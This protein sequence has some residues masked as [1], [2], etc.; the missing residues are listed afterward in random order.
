M[1]YKNRGRSESRRK[2]TKPER[3]TMNQSPLQWPVR[4]WTCAKNGT[5]V[6]LNER[7]LHPP[8][9]LI[10][11]VRPDHQSPPTPPSP[12]GPFGPPSPPSPPSPQRPFG[13]FGPK[14]S[15]FIADLD[16]ADGADG[17][18]GYDAA[19][20][21]YIAGDT[22]ENPKVLVSK[23]TISRKTV[24]DKLVTIRFLDHTAVVS[25]EQCEMPDGSM[26]PGLS[27]AHV[28]DHLASVLGAKAREKLKL[29]GTKRSR[30]NLLVMPGL[31]ED[32]KFN[33][34]QKRKTTVSLERK[35]RCD[36][37]GK[38]PRKSGQ[39]TNAC[40]ASVLMPDGRRVGLYVCLDCPSGP[41]G[42][43]G[44]IVKVT[45]N[46]NKHSALAEVVRS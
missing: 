32:M 15:S 27:E 21:A 14:T 8:Q 43:C 34:I 33:K 26:A 13:P 16:G 10:G 24:K 7:I 25:V 35:R 2:K 1:D 41:M 37:C 23:L 19:R 31:K 4:G 20:A 45:K 46:L 42:V 36:M 11:L 38:V 29:G 30:A 39:Q 22:T 9:V 18:S 44:Q 6:N 17:A 40:G 28:M 12:F 5:P 3:E